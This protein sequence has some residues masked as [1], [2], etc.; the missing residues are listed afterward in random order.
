MNH[1]AVLFED[2]ACVLYEWF[3]ADEHPLP[4]T[5]SPADVFMQPRPHA[6]GHAHVIIIVQHHSV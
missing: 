6:V 1:D 3:N 2:A 5:L 4:C